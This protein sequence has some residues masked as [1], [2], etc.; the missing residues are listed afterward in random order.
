VDVL[1]DDSGA[2]ISIVHPVKEGV[3]LPVI[4]KPHLRKLYQYVEENVRHLKATNRDVP[5]FG[6]L[7]Y[8]YLQS[9]LPEPHASKMVDPCY[10]EWQKCV[11]IYNMH[12]SAVDPNLTVVEQGEGAPISAASSASKPAAAAVKTKKKAKRVLLFSTA[13]SYAVAPRAVIAKAKPEEVRRIGTE[14]SRRASEQQQADAA[15]IAAKKAQQAAEAAAEAERRWRAAE[16]LRAEMYRLY[17]E[18]TLL[19]T[20]QREA[21]EKEEMMLQKERRAVFD[22]ALE[23]LFSVSK[24]GLLGDLTSSSSSDKKGAKKSAMTNKNKLTFEEIEKRTMIAELQPFLDYLAVVHSTASTLL[25][26]NKAG[27]KQLPAIFGLFSNVQEVNLSENSLIFVPPALFD[28]PNLRRLYLHHN[29]IKALPGIIN[30]PQLQ[31]LDLHSNNINLL[32]DL[33]LLTSLQTLDCEK[34]QIKLFPTGIEA[35]TNLYHLNLKSNQI[36]IVPRELGE[37]MNRKLTF[38]NLRYNP[39]VNL[40]PHI[41]QQGTKATLQFLLDHSGAMTQLAVHSHLAADLKRILLELVPNLASDPVEGAHPQFQPSLLC[42]IILKSKVDQSEFPCHRAI[43]WARCPVMRPTLNGVK[44]KR[45]N[46]LSIQSDLPLIPIDASSEHIKML[47]AY[48][49]SDSLMATT[50]K[51]LIATESLKVVDL[52]E[53]ATINSQLDQIRASVLKENIEVACKFDHPY[54]K[55]MVEMGD[56]NEKNGPNEVVSTFGEDMKA[57]MN[58]QN[59]HD[60]FFNAPSQD[61]SFLVSGNRF[62]IA[63]RSPFMTSLFT[64]GMMES[65][66]MV[67]CLGDVSIPVVRAILEFCYTDD[68]ETLDSETIVELLC[69]A[70]LYGLEKLQGI[71]ES[72]VGYSLDYANVT[73]ILTLAGQQQ[74]KTLARAAKFFI[75][76]NWNT[77]TSQPDWLEVPEEIRNVITATAKKWSV[78]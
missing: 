36:K 41:Y 71:V 14:E 53:M 4:S 52:A 33:S 10:R 76:S 75:L 7:V 29:R 35:C 18:R 8:T 44:P 42:D 63:S 48:W 37:F 1:L 19:E 20:Q 67:I 51:P 38:L 47:M 69:T 49:Y 31:N 59:E 16:K 40:P 65:Q 30:C 23:D 62:L 60:V 39:I 55:K 22:K 26:W 15:A 21:R 66:E 34:N 57:L 2:N 6:N 32:P 54:L 70:K 64:G 73:S 9:L 45:V 46:I 72:I 27:L 68:V 43:V 5:H 12:K 58:A 25:A 28:L 61:P 3:E 24:I 56:Q 78:V 11:D 13:Q 74:M 50:V 77:V 17:Q